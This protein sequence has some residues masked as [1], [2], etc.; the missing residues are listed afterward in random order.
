MIK[1]IICQGREVSSA[2]IAFLQSCVREH[3]DWSRHR[4]SKHICE[5]WGWRTHMGQLKTFAARSFIDKLEMREFIELPQVRT[6]MRRAHRNPYPTVTLPDAV[7]VIA[8]LS[9]I[10]PASITVVTSGSYDHGCFARY[11]T[12]HHYL[13]FNRTV[14]TP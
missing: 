14:G 4:I 3:P 2:D 5:Y 7:P 9:D 8:P 13:G 10:A 6:E 11:L 1:P 12:Q